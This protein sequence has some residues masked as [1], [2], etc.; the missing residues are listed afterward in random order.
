[1]L[2]DPFKLEKIAARSW[3]RPG[4]RLLMRIGPRWGHIAFD[5]GG[6]RGAPHEHGGRIAVESTTEPAWPLPTEVVSSGRYHGDEWVGDPSIWAYAQAPVPAHV[7]V[8]CADGL[9]AG[10]TDAWLVLSNQ[11]LAVVIA[12]S[13]AKRPE[14]EP[15]SGGWLARARALARDAQA[16]VQSGE[17]SL[18]TLWEARSGV[19]H[20]FG[21]LP[22]GREVEPVWFGQIAFHD[23]SALLIRMDSRTAAES[24]VTAGNALFG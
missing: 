21:A 22:L 5:I 1:M 8:G 24:V 3:C 4:E 10:R 12:A 13:A 14:A 17:E 16:M 9:A 18:L 2:K 20:H 6:R 23:G 11:R 7:A 15:Q 19:I